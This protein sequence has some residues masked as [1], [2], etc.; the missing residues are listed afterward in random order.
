MIDIT[1]MNV[2]VQGVLLLKK[3]CVD[4]TCTD[5]VLVNNP[6]VLLMK[7]S[8]VLTSKPMQA[9]VITTSDPIR[10]HQLRQVYY[11]ANWSI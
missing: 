3:A 8:P 5:K 2:I 1:G 11:V 7:I 6:E 10:W 9:D 4:I